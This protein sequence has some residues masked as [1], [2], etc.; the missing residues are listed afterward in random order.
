TNQPNKTSGINKH[1]TLL[2]SQTTDQQPGTTPGNRVGILFRSVLAISRFPR[3]DLL[4]LSPSSPLPQIAFPSLGDG[5]FFGRRIRGSA[6]FGAVGRN[7][8]S[9]LPETAPP[10]YPTRSR[11]TS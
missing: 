8:L 11:P 4:S 9:L 10:A 6:G 2:S 3:G 7:D 1:G 5:R